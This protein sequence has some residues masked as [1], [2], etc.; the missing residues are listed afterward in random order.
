MTRPNHT[1]IGTATAVPG[2]RARPKRSKIPVHP[3]D[4]AHRAPSGPN[5]AAERPQVKRIAMRFASQ[6]PGNAQDFATR[7][8]SVRKPLIL[9]P[10][11]K[12]HRA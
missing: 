4:P 6:S 7:L 2:E 12:T 8:R 1:V 9:R 10:K 3:Q 5:P 11:I